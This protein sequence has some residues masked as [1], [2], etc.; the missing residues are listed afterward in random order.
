[1]NNS[2][3]LTKVYFK[4]F[5]RRWV[6][7]LAMVVCAIVPGLLYL[8][9]TESIYE[10]QIRTLIQ[11]NGLSIDANTKRNKEKEFLSTQ[12]EIVRSPLIIRRSFEI[13]PPSP[14]LEPDVDPIVQITKELSVSPLVSTDII[15]LSYRNSDPERSVKR[16]QAIIESYQQ[17]LLEIEQGTSDE[18]LELLEN[19]EKT[20]SSQRKQL[21]AKL[22]QIRKESPFIGEPREVVR[23]ETTT[24]KELASQLILSNSKRVRIESAMQSQQNGSDT[25][26]ENIILLDDIDTELSRTLRDLQNRLWQAEA[27]VQ[28][29][30]SVYGP[31]FPERKQ[32][33]DQALALK[34]QYT[35]MK[36]Q[37]AVSL[38]RQLEIARA[39]EDNFQKQYNAERQRLSQLDNFLLQE[40]LL[41]AELKRINQTFESTVTQLRQKRLNKEALAGGQVSVLVKVLDEY[42]VPKQPVWPLPIPLLMACGLLGLLLALVIIAFIEKLPLPGM[43]F[44]DALAP[45]S[46]GFVSNQTST[47][48]EKS[49]PSETTQHQKY[50]QENISNGNGST[51]I[52]P[53]LEHVGGNHSS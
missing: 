15:R 2:T 26:S 11:N 17:Y 12:A 13:L 3:T 16:L 6:L 25:N 42:I 37:V 27:D 38:K 29:L 32:A 21:E 53:E 7:L 14:T 24:L 44:L 48:P 40:E 43:Q 49:I 5:R 18:T 46:T 39:E 10:T 28:K 41:Q 4:A 50:Q 19:Q 30:S 47:T 20:L 51:Q 9:N 52:L 23:T 22:I 35:D 45:E 36:S 34:K 8:Q 33:E 31:L 1:M